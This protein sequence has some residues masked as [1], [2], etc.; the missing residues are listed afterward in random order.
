MKVIIN[1]KTREFTEDKLKKETSLVGD[2]LNNL[3][4]EVITNVSA[5]LSYKIHEMYPIDRGHQL[6]MVED[7]SLYIRQFLDALNNVNTED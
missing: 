7:I 2:E 3:N 1:T 4:S 6:K 5:Y